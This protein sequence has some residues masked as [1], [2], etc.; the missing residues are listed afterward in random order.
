MSDAPQYLDAQGNPI[1][2]RQAAT[3]QAPKALDAHGEPLPERTWT[4][5]AVDALPM[6]GGAAG[7]LVGGIGGTVGGFGV[8]GVPGAMGG[9]ALGGGAG[10]AARQLVNRARGKAAPPTMGAAATD[11]GLEGGIQGALEGAGAVVM[12][13]LKLGA[14]AVY[15]GYLKPS[16]ARVNLPKA[17]QIV[18]NAIREALPVTEAGVQQAQSLI[19]QLNAKVNDILG[20]VEGRTVDLKDVA[21]RVRAWARRAYDRPGRDPNDLKAAL[22]VADRID[23]HPS[24]PRVAGP[25]T[26]ETVESAILDASGQPMT[27]VVEKAGP[28]TVDSRVT[29]PQAN[30]VKQDIQSAVGDKF[31]LPGGAATTR[32]EKTASN[33]LRRTIER[34]VP[35]VGPLNARESRLIDVA[36]AI[37]RATGREANK[38]PLIG[39]NTLASAAY[40]SEEY[41]RTGNPAEAAAKALA[42][43]MMLTPAVATRAALVASRMADKMPG[44]AAADIARVAVQVV[45]EA[46]QEP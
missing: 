5:T 22:A 30:Q 7:G 8:G 23:Q 3:M 2:S 39:V 29:L 43:R 26:T 40:G 14:Q 9:A 10:E 46:Q 4:D 15:R 21:N 33:V 13:V 41:A 18:K 38:S 24:L 31:G 34:Q 28:K 6:L 19:T 11:I 12:P 44:T 37:E 20:E 16:L 32:T 25:T 45:S 36:A 42:L 35:E 17:A 1:T 27:K